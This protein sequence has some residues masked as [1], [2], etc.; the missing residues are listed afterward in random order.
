[1]DGSKEEGTEIDIY[2]KTGSDD[3]RPTD[4]IPSSLYILICEILDNEHD[5]DRASDQVSPLYLYCYHLMS[6]TK[7][8]GTFERYLYVYQERSKK[9]NKNRILKN[10]RA[11]LSELYPESNEHPYTEEAITTPDKSLNGCRK[12]VHA[13]CGMV[14]CL[15]GETTRGGEGSVPVNDGGPGKTMVDIRRSYLTDAFD[16]G[17]TW[18]KG[19]GLYIPNDEIIGNSLAERRVYPNVFPKAASVFVYKDDLTTNIDNI[20]RL[21]QATPNSIMPFEHTELQAIYHQVVAFIN[22]I[23]I[24][25]LGD[26][27]FLLHIFKNMKYASAAKKS[28]ENVDSKIVDS[29]IVDSFTFS[30]QT[31]QLTLNQVTTQIGWGTKR[32]SCFN[33]AAVDINT[34]IFSKDMSSFMQNCHS[35][36]GKLCGDGVTIYA[37]NQCAIN[38]IVTSDGQ[39][40]ALLSIDEF[41]CLRAMV[42]LGVA[43]TN[44]KSAGGGGA[45]YSV[46]AFRQTP[47]SAFAGTGFGGLVSSRVVGVYR[48]GNIKY[49]SEEQAK[50]DA[51]AQIAAKETALGYAITELKNTLI[52]MTRIL[53]PNDN[54]VFNILAQKYVHNRDVFSINVDEIKTLFGGNTTKI[55]EFNEFCTRYTNALMALSDTSIVQAQCGRQSSRSGA[56]GLTNVVEMF[57]ANLGS[58]ESFLETC[59][60]DYTE[61]RTHIVYVMITRLFKNSEFTTA[62][63]D[64]VKSLFMMISQNQIFTDTLENNNVSKLDLDNA[65]I[66]TYIENYNKLLYVYNNLNNNSEPLSKDQRELKIKLRKNLVILKYLIRALATCQQI[67]SMSQTSAASIPTTGIAPASPK[68]IPVA[69]MNVSCID[70][71]NWVQIFPGITYDKV[72]KSYSIVT[73]TDDS[74]VAQV[75]SP[76]M[77]PGAQKDDGAQEDSLNEFL[78]TGQDDEECDGDVAATGAGGIS[79]TDVARQAAEE[80]T[81]MAEVARQAELQAQAQLQTL[82]KNAAVERELSR[83]ASARGTLPKDSK[84]GRPTRK[85]KPS[86]I[87]RRTIRRR[88]PR[89]TQK[90]TIRRQRRNNKRT[91][92]R[93]K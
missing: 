25:L 28:V 48:I 46:A 57:F 45:G 2:S 32:G 58:F 36:Y 82:E 26:G 42:L 87:P 55:S 67:K 79:L 83:R 22:Q 53:S 35:S 7:F 21:I 84:G 11:I 86:K 49:T 51:A 38:N 68:K 69:S 5:L 43:A 24:D 81:R 92:K 29:K 66:D 56:A 78:Q 15:I 19:G 4:A 34:M 1:M 64:F 12:F 74:P 37:T 20:I 30:L 47:S 13:D 63:P 3:R 54:N 44:A 18:P 31:G 40:P 93:R 27:P 80:A 73:T 71:F 8:W 23:N 89:R 65:N 76:A 10:M 6:G 39:I 70:V 50:L 33:A 61:S 9:M 59:G 16:N 14:G 75:L 60:F 88:A 77:S 85:R 41:C 91:Q 17:C 62:A 72:I 52:G 90:R